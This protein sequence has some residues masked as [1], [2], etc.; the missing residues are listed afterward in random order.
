MTVWPYQCYL[1]IRMDCDGW[2]AVFPGFPD[3]CHWI[4]TLEILRGLWSKMNY[5]I[6]L[7]PWRKNMV[8]RMKLILS[9]EE[10]WLTIEHFIEP[11]K[12]WDRLP[13]DWCRI[14]FMNSM[15]QIFSST[16]IKT[17]WLTRAWKIHNFCRLSFCRRRVPVSM[18]C[19]VQ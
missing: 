1:I 18:F 5:E 6:S 16:V 19:L 13:I 11:G 14:S 10:I 12:K 15:I 2:T 9:M 8:Y 4:D 7:L 17:T 3:H